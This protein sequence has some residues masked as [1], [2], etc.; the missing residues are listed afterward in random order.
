M[1]SLHLGL[2]LALTLARAP[3]RPDASAV[4]SRGRVVEVVDGDTVHVRLAEADERP[5]RKAGVVKV[6]LYGADAPEKEQP[7]GREATRALSSL[8]LGK[9]VVLQ[10]ITTDHFGRQVALVSVGGRD[11]SAALVEG[12]H[13]WAFRRYLGRRP[14]DERLCA[15]EYQARAARAGLWALEARRRDAPWVH[16][17]DGR[18]RDRVAAERS[19]EDCVRAFERQ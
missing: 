9:E 3:A 14:G 10:R 16:R 15:L 12:G 8:V 1:R 11:V 2:T 18:G 4:E 17:H 5:G 7:H 19:V 6:R 13:A